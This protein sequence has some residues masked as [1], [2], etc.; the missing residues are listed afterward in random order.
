VV[1]VLNRLGG[2]V[3]IVRIVVIILAGTPTRLVIRV[4]AA[5]AS[6][7]VNVLLHVA[8]TAFHAPLEARSGAGG[9]LAQTNL[10]LQ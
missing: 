8:A 2:A 3:I 1:V 6:I 5:S 9:A 7:A 4:C 10:V